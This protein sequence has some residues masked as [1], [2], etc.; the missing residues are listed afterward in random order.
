MTVPKD[1]GCSLLSS[2]RPIWVS[3]HSGV[4]MESPMNSRR[5]MLINRQDQ[6][7]PLGSR[8]GTLGL[9]SRA[10]YL[11]SMRRCSSL[12]G[13]QRQ[14]RELI[15]GPSLATKTRLLSPN[16]TQ[17]KVIKGLLTRHNTTRHLYMKRLTGSPWCRKCGAEEEISARVLW[18]PHLHIFWVTSFWTLRMLGI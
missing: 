9:R 5:V 6:S 4:E 11:T 10:G 15:L 1:T 17:K 16:R 8:G 13:N 3:G 14:A 18:R 12:S 7:Q 2:V